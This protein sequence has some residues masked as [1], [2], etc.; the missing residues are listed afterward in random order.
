MLFYGS[1]TNEVTREGVNV[2][3]LQGVLFVLVRWEGNRDVESNELGK[4][5][6]IQNLDLLK[7]F[8]RVRV[9]M[10]RG[11]GDAEINKSY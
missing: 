9:S 8:A 1:R 6:S 2:D 10:E 3:V 4:E 5:K 7:Y 11:G